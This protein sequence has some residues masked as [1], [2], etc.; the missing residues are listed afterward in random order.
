[1]ISTEQI[2]AMIDDPGVISNTQLDDLEK[3][4]QDYPFTPIFSQLY[5][6][7]LAHHDPITFEKKLKEHA[8]RVPDR[9][10]LYLLVNS[11]SEGN[12][13]ISKD[14]EVP[15]VQT[16]Q[17]AKEVSH[18]TVTEANEITPDATSQATDDIEDES[19]EEY[20]ES[21][22]SLRQEESLEEETGTREEPKTEENN[23][24]EKEQERDPLERD[25]LAHAV[26]SSIFLE[27]D[28]T[29]D[30]CEEQTFGKE[31]AHK[32]VSNDNQVDHQL[33]T[34]R[35]EREDEKE[36][37]KLEEESSPDDSKSE[38]EGPSKHS[39][40][41]WM[42]QFIA[43]EV[44]GDST[45]GNTQSTRSDQSEKNEEK[46]Q[47]EK[48][49]QSFFSPVKKAKESLDES[50][51]PVSETLAKIYI[52]QGNYPKAIEAYEKLLLNFPEKKSFFALQIESLKRKLK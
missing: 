24:E 27:I 38:Q 29:D 1:M 30:E 26:S 33:A 50:R 28:E 17:V 35:D 41:G 6:T 49:V 37:S 5:L 12:A 44:L 46:I 40:T 3:L 21:E 42:S 36:L 15:A 18:P 9:G 23:L 16:E 10:Q 22:D 51:L 25:I 34:D 52:A 32:V 7:G 2:A 47:E 4:S 14:D 19:A 31:G 13:E 20:A 8:Y 48:P 43:D 11:T 45:E 39:F